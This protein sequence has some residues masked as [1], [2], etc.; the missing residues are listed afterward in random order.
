MGRKVFISFLGT[1]NYFPSKYYRGKKFCSG[2]EKYVQIA[3]LEYIQ[4]I[5]GGWQ[6]NDIAYILLT[7]EAKKRNW[8]DNGHKDKDGNEIENLGLKKV[9]ENKG[10]PFQYEAVCD[11]PEGM[12]ETEIWEIFNIIYSRIENGD[13]LYFDITHGFRYLPMLV[14]V[15]GN[16]AKFLKKVKVKHIL[17]GNYEGRDKDTNNKYIEPAHSPLVDLRPFSNLQ[18]WTYSVADFINNGNAD[19]MFD[20]ADEE[21]RSRFRQ[22]RASSFRSLVLSI[23]DFAKDIQTC[24]GNSINEGTHIREVKRQLDEV[25][26]ILTKKNTKASID[27][28]LIPVFDRIKETM[29]NYNGQGDINNGFQAVQWCIEHRLYQQAVTILQES[30]KNYF[31]H[32]FGMDITDDDNRKNIERLFTVIKYLIN[33]LLQ[34]IEK[35]QDIGSRSHDELDSI[36]DLLPNIK[37]SQDAVSSLKS[38]KAIAYDYNTLRLLRNDLNH[39]GCNKKPVNPDNIEQKLRES[40]CSITKKLFISIPNLI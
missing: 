35:P 1:T 21:L 8:E 40:Y 24:R 37:K 32:K 4:A 26:E 28:L 18:D 34:Y 36:K 39:F 7:K 10:F 30:V 2:M 14:V 12:N 31:L 20:L 13:E 29:E 23:K 17:Y 6:E 27:E 5:D 33:P 16:Y 19:R 22:E 9:L 38:M 25:Y 11:I 15:L 3:A